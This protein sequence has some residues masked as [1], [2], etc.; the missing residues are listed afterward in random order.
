MDPRGRRDRLRGI[1]AGLVDRVEVAIVPVLLGAG[2]PVLPG[3]EGIARLELHSS[4][5]FDSG[6]ALMKYDVVRR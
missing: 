5:I 6:I 1:E 4:E 2:V 3:L